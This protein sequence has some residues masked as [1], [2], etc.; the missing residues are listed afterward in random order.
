MTPKARPAIT[1]FSTETAARARSPTWPA[2]V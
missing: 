1:E 2:K